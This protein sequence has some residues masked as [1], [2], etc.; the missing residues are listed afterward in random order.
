[1]LFSRCGFPLAAL[2]VG[3]PPAQLSASLRVL[4]FVS[5]LRVCWSGTQPTVVVAKG[6][7]S[8]C[9]VSRAPITEKLSGILALR[10]KPLH[11]STI[12]HWSNNTLLKFKGFVNFQET[13]QAFGITLVSTTAAESRGLV[14]RIDVF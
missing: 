3:S 5:A 8:N 7:I 11:F 9:R 2:S 4:H 10:K 13:S 1:L 12:T 14:S 6:K